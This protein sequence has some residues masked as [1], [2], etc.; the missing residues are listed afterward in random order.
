VVERRIRTERS[1]FAAVLGE[2][3]RAK[4]LLEASGKFPQES[5]SGCSIVSVYCEAMVP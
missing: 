2:R 1:P 5:P 4:V 3:E